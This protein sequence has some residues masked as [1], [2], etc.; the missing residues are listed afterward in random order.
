MPSM[1]SHTMYFRKPGI[2][3]FLGCRSWSSN[4]DHVRIAVRIPRATLECVRCCVFRA[5]MRVRYIAGP[6]D[7]LPLVTATGLGWWSMREDAGSSSAPGP[8]LSPG[9]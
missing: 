1:F 3:I 6:P 5:P 9:G 4:D 7:D 2:S 8:V